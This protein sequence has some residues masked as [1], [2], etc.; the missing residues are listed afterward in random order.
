MPFAS[1]AVTCLRMN[2]ELMNRAAIKNSTI[3]ITVIVT[4]VIRFLGAV[5]V[6]RLLPREFDI[7]RHPLVCKI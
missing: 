1:T 4:A 7:M 3:T 6:V 5:F 2:F